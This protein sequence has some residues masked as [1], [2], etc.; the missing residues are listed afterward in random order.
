MDLD[1]LV[2]YNN[3]CTYVKGRNLTFR[4]GSA[5]MHTANTKAVRAAVPTLYHEG[6]A[7]VGLQ[8]K[9]TRDSC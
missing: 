5:S 8:W 1:M 6:M 7:Y 4:H 2:A 9:S 3:L